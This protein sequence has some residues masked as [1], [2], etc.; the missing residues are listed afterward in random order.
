MLPARCRQEL[1][2]EDG[3]WVGWLGPSK[4]LVVFASAP[5]VADILPTAR[6]VRHVLDGRRTLRDPELV[7]DA[8]H[9][10]A[11]DE[12]L[13]SAVAVLWRPER[14]EVAWIGDVR[15]HL[16]RRGRLVAS[17]RDHTLA[18]ELASTM[19]CEDNPAL[20]RIV[21]RSLGG[22]SV[23]SDAQTWTLAPGDAL[24]LCAAHLH[25]FRPP[26]H[27]LDDALD[28]TRSLPGR[29]LIQDRVSPEP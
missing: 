1:S 24:L 12:R 7:L 2:V 28:P 6:F 9:H 29:L 17:T 5:V 25:D 23:R 14:A 20:A 16:I 13:L 8:L 19:T 27:Y 3:F 11:S 18:N 15:G 22:P 26:A 4:L 10:C 21:T